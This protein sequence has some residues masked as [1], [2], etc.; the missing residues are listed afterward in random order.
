MS[1]SW[2]HWGRDCSEGPLPNPNGSSGGQGQRSGPRG[3]P[4]A[5]GGGTVVGVTTFLAP[6]TYTPTPTPAMGHAPPGSYFRELGT[7]LTVLLLKDS[8]IN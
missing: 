8:N 7:G 2:F 6:D 1:V 3:E 5:A 4:W